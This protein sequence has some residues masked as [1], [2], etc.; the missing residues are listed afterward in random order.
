MMVRHVLLA[1]CIGLLMP[2]VLAQGAADAQLRQLRLQVRQAMQAARDAQEAADAAKAD[3]E[4]AR[5][6]QVELQTALGEAA[7][8]RDAAAA[9]ASRLQQDKAA[10]EAKLVT[11]ESALAETRGLLAAVRTELNAQVAG[12][13]TAEAGLR[14][15]DAALATC[16]AHNGELVG[17]AN[18]L[19]A[20]YQNKGV[21][22]V[23]GEGE[24]LTGIGRVRLEN[25]LE[26]YRD[27][28]DAAAD[29]VA[30]SSPAER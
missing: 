17:V 24:P 1:V 15:T 4:A 12:R 22:D 21:F 3:A 13:R 10:L 19:L 2:P 11:A 29:R 25:L 5:A 14:D 7:G 30:E 18:D 27:K 16:R 23:L 20:A 28:V 26:T 9:S 8:R 6:Q